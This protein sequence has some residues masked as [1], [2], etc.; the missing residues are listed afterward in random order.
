MRRKNDVCAESHYNRFNRIYDADY[1]L[2]CKGKEGQANDYRLW[3]HGSCIHT[4]P[5]MYVGVK[6]IGMVYRWYAI[7]VR[8]TNSPRGRF[9]SGTFH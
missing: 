6:Q 4:Y 5:D 3:F 1:T 2:V 7:A 8:C 9:D